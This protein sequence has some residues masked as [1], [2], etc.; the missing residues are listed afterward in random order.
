MVVRKTR[1]SAIAIVS[2]GSV[3][4]EALRAAN[5]LA[6]EGI[7]VDVINARFAAP[8]DERIIA[9]LETGKSIITVEDHHS[10][11]GFGSAVLELVAAKAGA[12]R[13]YQR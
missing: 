11:C 2:Y 12:D 10:A 8:V 13:N 1:D 9:L 7:A 5:V 3:L 4:T 6:K